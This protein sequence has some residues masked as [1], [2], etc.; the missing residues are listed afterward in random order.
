[1]TKKLESN[2]CI[3]L[4]RSFVAK[5]FIF[6]YCLVRNSGLRVPSPDDK[7]EGPQFGI[8]RYGSISAK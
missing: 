6:L 3:L 4:S 8:E 5:L 1:M 2:I 7:G